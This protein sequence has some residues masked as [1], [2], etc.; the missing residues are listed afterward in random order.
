GI[1]MLAVPVAILGALGA[2]WLRGLPNDVF[3]Q[4]GLVM[5]IGLAARNAIL[6]VEFSKL[7]RDAGLGI[8]DAALEAARR[9]FR[10]ILM[11]S[12]AFIL[13]IAPLVIASGAGSAARRSL[14]TAVFGGMLAATT[15]TILFVPMFYVVV[16][17]LGEGRLF[18]RRR[19]LGEQAEA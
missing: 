16:Q 10:P 11:T 7:R 17:R 5:L 12:L 15:L 14:G 3:C 8:V 1:I 6:I 9:R 2:Q 4:I 18:R 13:G 19:P